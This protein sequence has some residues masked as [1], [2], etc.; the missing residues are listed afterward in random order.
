MGKGRS[1]L[2]A[3]VVISQNTKPSI[4]LREILL[5][6]AT[7]ISIRNMMLEDKKII[8]TQHIGK[9]T[10]TEVLSSIIILRRKIKTL[11]ELEGSL[12]I[13]EGTASFGVSQ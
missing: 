10:P 11:K 6:A 7:T 9:L 12:M 4:A 8:Q 13:S 3:S 2:Y 1:Y 5:D